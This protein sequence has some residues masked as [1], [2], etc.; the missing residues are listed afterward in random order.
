[1]MKAAFER[2]FQKLSE[3]FTELEVARAAT[4]AANADAIAELRARV[5]ALEVEN[6]E[7]KAKLEAMER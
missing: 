1:M 4:V 7:M 6:A 5:T 2:F 3:A